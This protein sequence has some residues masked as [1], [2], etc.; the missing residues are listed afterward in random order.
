MRTL[1]LAAALMAA[2]FAHA[3]FGVGQQTALVRIQGHVGVPREDDRTIAHFTLRRSEATIDFTV[4]EI[5]VL[6]GNLVGL[7]IVNEVEP[8]TPSMTVSGPAK[9]LDRLS[10]APPDEKLEINGYY[11]RGARLLIPRSPEPM[12]KGR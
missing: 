7:D 12:N 4:D 5:W 3:G 8:Y 1:L 6:S 10:T 2:S 9:V 11:R